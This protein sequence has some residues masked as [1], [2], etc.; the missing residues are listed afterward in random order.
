MH[1]W[2]KATYLFSYSLI[3]VWRICMNESSLLINNPFA[4]KQQDGKPIYTA[5][6]KRI[7][8]PYT[9]IE[10][11]DAKKTVSV[12]FKRKFSEEIVKIR[13]D[14]F[15]AKLR[16]KTKKIEVKTNYPI[17]LN[18]LERIIITPMA[19][20]YIS[21]F[22]INFIKSHNISIIWIDGKGTVEASF[23]P[24]DFKKASLIIK[25]VEARN[26]GKG[27]DIA[28]YL[29]KLKIESEDMKAYL[30]KLNKAKDIKEV[31]EVEALA[32]AN[33]F[34]KWKFDKEWSFSGRHGKNN[35][36][37]AVDPV[38][39]M[40]NLGYGLLAQK[41]SQILLKRGFELSIGFLHAYD[42]TASWNR[43]TYDL[44]EPYRTWIDIKVFELIN[45]LRIK[46]DDF[47]FKDD[48]SS[49]I[50]KDESF[51]IAIE[52]FVDSLK[53]L[54]NKSLPLIRKIEQM[55]D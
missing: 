41:M 44:I 36:K 27:L 8:R 42:A 12:Y 43:L 21:T 31:M 17:D 6:G 9:D 18:K 15:E 30:P 50:F 49:M 37:S 35:N 3:N 53:L 52:E 1:E 7:E 48:K 33:Y 26:N 55:M 23:M 40:L 45:G 2:D 28:K 13:L 25:Q 14:T 46:P 54:E 4:L 47:T 22:F 11:E 32:S 16:G 51:K 19:H 39:A 38:N 24:D 29:I 10:I 34:K 5:I 20:G